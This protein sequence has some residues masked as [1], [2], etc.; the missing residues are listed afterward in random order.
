MHLE[1]VSL[2]VAGAMDQPVKSHPRHHRERQT[3]PRRTNQNKK[4]P[5]REEEDTRSATSSGA[6][7]ARMMP[8]PPPLRRRSGGGIAAPPPPPDNNNNSVIASSLVSGRHG[9]QRRVERNIDKPTLQAARRY[10]MK[11]MARYGREMYTYQGVT[12]SE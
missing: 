1:S 3:S 8:P 6:A 10:G 5:P 2:F 7:A 11:E 4:K 9:R 12:F